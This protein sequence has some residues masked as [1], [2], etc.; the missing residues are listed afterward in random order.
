MS[1][2]SQGRRC[3]LLH[4]TAKGRLWWWRSTALVLLVNDVRRHN[5]SFLLLEFGGL[6]RIVEQVGAIKQRNE[7]LQPA[8]GV[9]HCTPRRAAVDHIFGSDVLHQSLSA[10]A[11]ISSSLTVVLWI[12][13]LVLHVH[14][15]A[16][17]VSDRTCRS[18]RRANRRRIHQ[19]HQ[20]LY[21]AGT[22]DHVAGLRYECNLSKR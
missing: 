10:F 13:P 1:N 20:R 9:D 21:A 12:D 19:V 16:T 14:V 17:Y 2:V 6:D 3:L 22:S 11:N 7:S 4:G 15:F 8:H 5:P 18:L